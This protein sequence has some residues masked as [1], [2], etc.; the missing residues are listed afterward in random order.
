MAASRHRQAHRP[1]HAGGSAGPGHRRVRPEGRLLRLPVLALVVALLAGG[2]VA[3]GVAATST[4]ARSPLPAAAVVAPASSE[5]TAWYCAGGTGSSGG[6][7]KGRSYL[8]N[9]TSH[10]VAA[11]EHVVSDTGR[12]AS[13][14]LTVPA[15]GQVAV[16]P[17]QH[18]TGHWLA[19]TFVTDGGGVTAMESVAGP[20]GWSQAPCATRASSTWYFPSGSTANGQDLYL[21]L[22]NAGA[23][24]A[25]V[26]LSFATAGGPMAPQ[27]FQG[28]VVPPGRLSAIDVGALVQGQSQIST[29]VQ[30]VSGSVVADSLELSGATGDQGLALELGTPAAAASWSFPS[31]FDRSGG[32]TTFDVFNPT[33]APERVTVAPRVASGP[34]AP[35]VQT[36]PAQSTWVLAA[37]QSVRFPT[38]TDYSVRVVA[39]GGPG[40]VVDRTV[41]GPADGA[42]PQWGASSG[43]IDAV[44]TGRPGSQ[45]WLV[46]APGSATGSP[47]VAGAIFG[48]LGLRN[49]TS[50]VVRVT[51][52]ELTPTGPAAIVGL[53]PFSLNPDSFEV[54]D[55]AA[56]APADPR[57]LL[58]SASGPV[59]VAA[60]S[61]PVGA[62]GVVSVPGFGPL[63]P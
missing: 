6:F 60:E 38:S 2:T 27:P 25:V 29:T 40:V 43:I 33:G 57:S 47:V 55:Q 56:L 59:A 8:D 32:R 39:Q 3:A 50:S 41:Q 35:L 22:Y 61:E 11:V 58:V 12:T 20:N 10:P 42:S 48:G 52:S 54:L 26:N 37:S 21:S 1:G 49:L 28:V 19:S 24:S 7:A 17:T 18:L 4:P 36:V 51:V 13:V 23:T 62:P 5:S 34:L 46:P 9:S 63:L 30:A 53:G 45:T 15:F 16:D 31:S 14:P 44:S